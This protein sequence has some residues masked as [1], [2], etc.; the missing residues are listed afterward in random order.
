MCNYNSQLDTNLINLNDLIIRNN[1]D[2]KWSQFVRKLRT[3]Q[4]ND[5]IFDWHINQPNNTIARKADYL[6]FVDDS[7]IDFNNIPSPPRDLNT[8][9]PTANQYDYITNWGE[10]QILTK[11]SAARAE[12]FVRNLHIPFNTTN[13]LEAL[14]FLDT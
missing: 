6:I 1:I 2:S 7:S 14:R 8:Y 4:H 13:L 3:R 11:K 5:I 9:N 12:T 10:S